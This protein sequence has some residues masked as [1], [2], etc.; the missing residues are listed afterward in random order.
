MQ[1]SLK[2]L[3][4]NNRFEQQTFPIAAIMF[5]CSRYVG[6]YLSYDFTIFANF[7][8]NEHIFTCRTTL[9]Q[10]VCEVSVLESSLFK[11]NNFFKT[12]TQEC[13]R[14]YSWRC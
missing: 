8:S 6:M 4:D 13:N 3:I 7:A 14:V 5:A 1:K 2:N 10:L 9:R 11:L 12:V